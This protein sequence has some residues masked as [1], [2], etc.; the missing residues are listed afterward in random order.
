MKYTYI[1]KAL[2]DKYFVIEIYDEQGKF[3]NKVV[4]EIVA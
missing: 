2:G 4:T 1:T 3:L